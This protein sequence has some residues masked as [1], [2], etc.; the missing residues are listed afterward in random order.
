MIRIRVRGGD[1]TWVGIWN[2]AFGVKAG[3]VARVRAGAGA[4]VS[5]KSS[6]SNSATDSPLNAAF[7]S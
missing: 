5:A 6:K 3:V 2:G 4:W 7:E 1:R